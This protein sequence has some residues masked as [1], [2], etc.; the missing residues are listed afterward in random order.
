MQTMAELPHELFLGLNKIISIWHM[1]IVQY[2]SLHNH[3]SDEMID[4]E[5]KCNTPRSILLVSG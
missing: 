1:I 4:L 5:L 2:Q 3:F